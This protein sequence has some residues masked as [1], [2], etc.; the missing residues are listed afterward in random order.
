MVMR[1]AISVTISCTTS[2]TERRVKSYFFEAEKVRYEVSH[3][4]RV[5]IVLF[6]GVKKYGFVI[7]RFI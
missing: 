1:Y 6:S 3:G 4:A 2:R 7:L 5:K